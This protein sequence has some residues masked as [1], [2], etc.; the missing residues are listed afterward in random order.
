MVYG[1]V[2]GSLFKTEEIPPRSLS[3]VFPGSRNDK[4]KL[5]ILKQ[6]QNDGLARD[7]RVV[8]STGLLAMTEGASFLF[9]GTSSFVV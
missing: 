4:S 3:S 5:V 2:E 9:G 6:V 7:C 1:E 8:P